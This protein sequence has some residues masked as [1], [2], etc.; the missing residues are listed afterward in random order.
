MREFA[1]PSQATRTILDVYRGALRDRRVLCSSRA[2]HLRQLARPIR[3]LISK[4]GPAGLVTLALICKPTGV[5]TGSPFEAA[6]E[7]AG[8]AFTT[9]AGAAVSRFGAPG[10]N[11]L[12]LRRNPSIRETY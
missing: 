4:C 3:H 10:A 9:C 2:I 7:A 12:A 1:A 5:S 11:R 8:S 6:G